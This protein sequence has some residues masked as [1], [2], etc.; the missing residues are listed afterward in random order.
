[1]KRLHLFLSM[2]AIV[3]AVSCE[4]SGLNADNVSYD[5]GSGVEHGLIV[6]GEKLNDPYTVE[7][8]T[9]AIQA[10]YPTKGNVVQLTPTDNYVRL[11]PHNDEDLK[12]LE[13]MG[14][15]MLDHPLDY[16]IVKEGD[17]YHD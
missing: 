4:R 17:Y 3:A 14:V 6:L 8:M 9:K 5:D 16:M 11:L 10:V 7:N 2:A 13:Q 1:M 12:S 15:Q